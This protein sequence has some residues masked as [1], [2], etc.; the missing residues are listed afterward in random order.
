MKPKEVEE[1]AEPLLYCSHGSR[2]PQF[3]KTSL[4]LVVQGRAFSA[5]LAFSRALPL[6]LESTLFLPQSAQSQNNSWLL[7][8]LF[9][10]HYIPFNF[11]LKLIL[12]SFPYGKLTTIP[13][14]WIYRGQRPDKSST[15]RS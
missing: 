15:P 9:Y 3:P 5:R 14:G 13:Q 12:G 7:W 10:S 8:L 11:I 2:N 1:K 4:S 6:H